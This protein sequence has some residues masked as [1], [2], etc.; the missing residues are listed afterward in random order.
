MGWGW[1]KA[2]VRL[3]SGRR[4]HHDHLTA[5]HF[6][7]GFNPGAFFHFL[8][9]TLEDLSSEFLV[10]HLAAAEPQGHLDLVTGIDEFA[11]ILH[12]HLVVMLINIGTELD[13]LD[14]DNLL[15]FAGFIGTFL[16]FVF[17]FA[18]IQDLADGRV[19]IRLNFNQIETDLISTA[20]GIIHGD[21]T[22]LL[23]IFI[24]TTDTGG[25]NG[26]VNTGAG[27][28]GWGLEGA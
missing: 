18:V 22:E 24:N 13:F 14:V 27:T 7:H 15:L 9:D 3:R 12:L 8:A 5:F 6:G 17:E 1:D 16:G 11:D 25:G 2:E 28:R 23:T 20:N 4:Q 10:G 19:N 21:D 26:A